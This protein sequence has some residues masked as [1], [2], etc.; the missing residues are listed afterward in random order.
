MI[1]NNILSVRDCFLWTIDHHFGGK[2]AD[3]DGGK[4]A[5]IDGGKTG[6][7]VYYVTV[8]QVRFAPPFLSMTPNE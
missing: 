2:T 5:D 1:D 4:A 8:K 7:I 3:T 6:G